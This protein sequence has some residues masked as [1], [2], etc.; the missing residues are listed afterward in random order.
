MARCARVFGGF[1]LAGSH[2]PRGRV[3]PEEFDRTGVEP[4]RLRSQRE[5]ADGPAWAGKGHS[6]SGRRDR[7]YVPPGR[8]RAGRR[9]YVSMPP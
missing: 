9:E 6:A 4:C 5:R 8:G 2:K 3:E 7:P 1:I